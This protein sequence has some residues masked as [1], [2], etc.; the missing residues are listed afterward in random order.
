MPAPRWVARANKIGLNRF[1]KYIAPWAPGW[2]IVVHRGRK[3]GRT[4][5]TPLWAFR[6]HNGFVIALTYGPETDW[7]RNVLAAGGCELQT[8]RRRYQLGAPVV[9][10]DE[11]ATDMPAFIRFMLRRV[12]KAPEFLRL[13][14]VN[15]LATA[16]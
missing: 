16:R 5:R 15:Q 8:R 6:R 12:I 3:S 4:F 9:F 13:D 2:A 11:D 7:V 14:I 1:T 10:R